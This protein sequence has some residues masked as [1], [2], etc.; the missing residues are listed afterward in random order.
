MVKC[1]TYIFNKCFETR[2]EL[3]EFTDRINEI[4]RVF[5]MHNHKLREST[6]FKILYNVSNALICLKVEIEHLKEG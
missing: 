2:K 4:I 1:K 3:A 5:N 6:Q